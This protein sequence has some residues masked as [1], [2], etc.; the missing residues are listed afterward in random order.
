VA[1][2]G[3]RVE[4]DIVCFHS[5]FVPCSTW[6]REGVGWDSS[7]SSQ[8]YMSATVQ[9]SMGKGVTDYHVR[10][11]VRLTEHGMDLKAGG[12]AGRR[13]GGGVAVHAI[14]K[15]PWTVRAGGFILGP[16]QG[17]GQA[18]NMCTCLYCFII[19]NNKSTNHLVDEDTIV[20]GHPT[21]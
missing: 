17:I 20:M 5:F 15:G 14:T 7:T 4:I 9:C 1:L 16:L 2:V 19:D 10:R 21:Q 18:L 6:L 8:V 11:P 12:G 3:K 13:E